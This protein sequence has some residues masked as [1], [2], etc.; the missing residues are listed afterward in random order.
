MALSL[1]TDF[2]LVVSEHC[3]LYAF[4][5]NH[6]GQLGLGTT[7]N[8]LLPA[9]VDKVQAFAGEQVVSVSCGCAHS[10]CVTRE[11]NL[12]VWGCNEEGQLGL[13]LLAQ[14]VAVFEIPAATT[15]DDDA[16][17][18]TATVASTSSS[19]APAIPSPDSHNILRPVLVP[20]ASFNNA[21]VRMVVCGQNF[22]LAL[23]KY[24]RVFST[25]AND[26]GQLGLNDT[27]SRRVFAQIDPAFFTDSTITLIAAGSR[28]CM[29]LS[30]QDGALF[31]FG[32]NRWSQLGI[33][34]KIC[35]QSVPIVVPA[36]SFGGSTPVFV[37]AGDEFSMAVMSDGSLY[38]CGMNNKYQLGL[39][40]NMLVKRMRRVED[41]GKFH[42]QRV[43]SV[44][45]GS[46]HSMIM[47]EDNTLWAC[48]LST[49]PLCGISVNPVACFVKVPTRI[50]HARF[51][52]NDVIVFSAGVSHSAAITSKG[53]LYTWGKGVSYPRSYKY[54]F[55][56]LGQKNTHTQWLPR[57]V[58]SVYLGG[59]RVGAWNGIRQDILLA[60]MMVRH[61][62][63]G[64][65]S[66]FQG[67]L[68]EIIDIIFAPVCAPN[69]LGGFED[70]LG[71]LPA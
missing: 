27:R 57:K 32:C 61:K 60:F 20:R 68:C 51:H 21:P 52:G 69:T 37:D 39:G 5:T 66:V 38:G 40:D 16:G 14:P 63:L 1:G 71:R 43:R 18:T 29:A 50:P 53:E 9:L 36:E 41:A 12:F 48:G 59:A 31:V 42:G 47:T 15:A 25:G 45:C 3:D 44:R 30:A 7:E 33:D 13:D 55:S 58:L 70:L 22:T 35:I 23:T 49:D 2:T 4:G 17:T 19:A 46:V 6:N 10:A 8:Q 56:A 65:L 64:D 11:D 28:H 24:G 67:L 54:K 62:R 34:C 26:R